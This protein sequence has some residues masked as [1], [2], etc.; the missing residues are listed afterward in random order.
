V[1][2]VS[3][4]TDI[5][6]GE[7]NVGVKSLES[8]PCHELQGIFS[9]SFRVRYDKIYGIQVCPLYMLESMYTWTFS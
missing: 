6:L 1:A 9:V 8:S 5:F 7:M 2:E 4:M 3:N